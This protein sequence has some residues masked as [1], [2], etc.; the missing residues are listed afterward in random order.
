MN[1][2]KENLILGETVT[3]DKNFIN[4]SKVIIKSFTPNK[5]FATIYDADDPKRLCW[6]VMTV[7]LTR[8]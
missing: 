3:L 7:R 6:Q 5:M 8:K 2:N 1:H 4:T